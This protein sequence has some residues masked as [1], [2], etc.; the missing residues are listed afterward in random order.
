LHIH[1]DYGT[2]V[3]GRGYTN[4]NRNPGLLCYTRH[5]HGCPWPLP[6][7]NHEKV[8]CCVVP[9]FPSNSKARRQRCRTCGQWA[10]GW[11]LEARRNLPFQ[12]N[13]ACHHKRVKEDDV[14]ERPM[15]RCLD[16]NLYWEGKRPLSRQVGSTFAEMLD[17]ICPTA[18]WE[19]LAMKKGTP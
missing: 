5:L 11:I 9:D 8:R 18:A 3:Q 17:K 19:T 14:L 2:F 4:I 13:V 7:P 15:W 12:E 6:E 16:C 10:T 1:E